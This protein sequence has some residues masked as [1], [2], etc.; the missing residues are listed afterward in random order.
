MPGLKD[1]PHGLFGGTFGVKAGDLDPAFVLPAASLPSGAS[2]AAVI[3]QGGILPDQLGKTVRNT[4]GLS[5]PA[6]SLVYESGWASGLPLIS[7]AVGS[8]QTTHATWVTLAAIA[9]NANGAV[10]KHFRLSGID[11]SSGAA[12]N[13]VYLGTTTPGGYAIN[14]V[15]N[16]T[17]IYQVVGRVA[18]A[19]SGTGGSIDFDLLAGDTYQIVERASATLSAIATTGATVAYWI[20]PHA[21]TILGGRAVFPTSLAIDG[22]NY[23]IISVTNKQS[24][25][26][27]IA[28]LATVAPANSTFTGGAAITADTA[29]ALTVNPTGANLVFATGDI[30]KFAVTVTGTLGGALAA[31]STLTLPFIAS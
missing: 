31:G 7:L 2:I 23:V 22:T 6:G 10:G 14:V 21:G 19:A 15:D 27:A 25:A 12:G 26:G 18:V 11:T 3:P 29:Y 30:L 13:P 20:A 17:Q 9:N 4:S 8:G 1:L 5:I 16:L 28:M 24:G